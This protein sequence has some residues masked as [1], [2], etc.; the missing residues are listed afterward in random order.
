MPTGKVGL[1]WGKSV[2]EMKTACLYEI[3]MYCLPIVSDN[4]KRW[5]GLNWIGL[6]WV[7]LSWVDSVPEMKTMCLYEIKM[8]CFPIGTIGKVGL[9]W[10]GETQ[11]L[12][13]KQRF[14]LK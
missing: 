4:L 5:V 3:K 9:G 8:C 12:K 6:G 1:V 13:S 7:G 11:L 2:S 10:I 14:S